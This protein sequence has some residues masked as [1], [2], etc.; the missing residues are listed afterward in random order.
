MLTPDAASIS[1]KQRQ[2]LPE[3]RPIM[4]VLRSFPTL[5]ETFV[6]NEILGLEGQ[7]E[8]LLVESLRSAEPVPTHPQL[9]NL[10]ARVRY[11][12]E[13][14]RRRRALARA[15]LELMFRRPLVWA[16]EALTARRKGTFGAFKVAGLI[17]R[18][19]R[20]TRTRHI[21]VH[22]AYSA[23]P[24]I[25]AAVLCGVACT[26]HVHAWD[27][28][29]RS[30][31]PLVQSR[32]G[33]AAAVVSVSEHNVSHLRSVLSG[34][35]AHHS[36]QGVPVGPP[37]VLPADGPLLSIARFVPKKGLDVLVAALPEILSEA[38]GARLEVIGDG[39]LRSELERQVREFGVEESTDLRRGVAGDE[40][41]RALDR[42]SMFVLPCRIDPAGDRDGLPTVLIEALSRGVPV[43]TTDIV[44]ISELVRHG[45]T[46]LL[47]PP[48]DPRA[49]ARAVLE[50][51]ADREHAKRLGQAG[52]DLVASRHSP[53]AAA[54]RLQALFA[55]PRHLPA[56]RDTPVTRWTRT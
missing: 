10:H 54:K 20:L 39:P 14:P 37:S 12:S 16:R 41:Q 7:G 38:P 21:H 47:V 9:S 32:L 29:H 34:V 25:H 5:T 13:I 1:E 46:G 4:Y 49:L 33:R 52:R 36:P 11:L 18:R 31:A 42:C 6:L 22:F 43:V 8:R 53:E 2:G 27:I 3:P 35:P 17:A 26:V 15:H 24:A 50:L 19:A 40:V 23:D 45:E 28:F 51:M 48:D 30:Q 56:I 44:G 55:E